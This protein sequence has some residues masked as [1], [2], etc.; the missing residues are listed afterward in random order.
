MQAAL[1]WLQLPQQDA[2]NIEEKPKVH[3]EAEVRE[4]GRRRSGMAP[5]TWGGV[6]L[7]NQKPRVLEMSGQ[8]TG[9]CRRAGAQVIAL[10]RGAWSPGGPTCPLLREGAQ[11]PLSPPWAKLGG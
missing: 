5:G 4:G 10:E 3:L 11:G 8:I 1:S 2:N 6:S 9:L 7:G